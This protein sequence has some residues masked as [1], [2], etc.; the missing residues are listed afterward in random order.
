MMLWKENCNAEWEIFLP[1]S[2]IFWTLSD[3]R[4]KSSFIL[5]SDEEKK[6]KKSVCRKRRGKTIFNENENFRLHTQLTQANST[7]EFSWSMKSTTTTTTKSE[8]FQGF[9]KAK[10]ML[11]CFSFSSYI[12]WATKV[13]S[14]PS[15]WRSLLC[16]SSSLL[17]P[18]SIFLTTRD[19][20]WFPFIDRKFFCNFYFCNFSLC[21]Y[22]YAHTALYSSLQYALSLSLIRFSKSVLLR[23]ISLRER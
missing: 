11:E 15:L 1:F 20:W 4:G 6:R 7:L 21:F 19:G 22:G 8:R 23:L 9:V 14:L 18:H 17:A 10:E 16:F 12:I 3:M 5:S 2:S 13:R